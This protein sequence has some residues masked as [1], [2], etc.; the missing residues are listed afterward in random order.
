[1]S[2]HIPA[3]DPMHMAL[4][5]AAVAVAYGFFCRLNALQFHRHRTPVVIF[6][7]LGFG[8]CC[9]T[10]IDAWQGDVTMAHLCFVAF[11]ACWLLMSLPTWRHGKPPGHV[12]SDFGT[13]H[14]TTTQPDRTDTA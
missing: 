13:L 14:S 8:A 2:F 7:L 1:M 12:S 4:L 10:A 3:L 5:L 6:H 11:A 9:W